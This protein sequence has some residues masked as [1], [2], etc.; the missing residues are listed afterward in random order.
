MPHSF[1][2]I[3]LVLRLSAFLTFFFFLLVSETF[4]R[5]LK[6]VHHLVLMG[7]QAAPEG[8]RGSPCASAEQQFAFAFKMDQAACLPA[9]AAFAELSLFISRFASVCSQFFSRFSFLLPSLLVS[10]PTA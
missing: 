2:L 6:F 4:N 9:T 3:L 5:G 7:A 8:P 10:L 1:A